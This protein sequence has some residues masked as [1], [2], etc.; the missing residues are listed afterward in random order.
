MLNRNN[1]KN[2]YDLTPMQEGILL[3]FIKNP[4]SV[5]YNEQFDFTLK[6]EISSDAIE[7]SFAALVN[8]YDVLR[9]LFSYKKTDRPKQIVLKSWQPQLRVQ[10]LSS[11]E[12]DRKLQEWLQIKEKDHQQRFNLSSDNLIRLSLIKFSD[13]HCQL[14][15]TFHH[16]ILDGWCFSG[17]LADFFRYYDIFNQ[18]PDSII[19]E[20]EAVT[21]AQ[22]IDWIEKQNPQVA[23]DYW[24]NYLADYHNEVG[25]PYFD[26]AYQGDISHAEYQFNLG[27]TLTAKMIELSKQ[28]NVTVNGLFQTAWGVLLQKIN[29]T[30]DV[31]FG[32]VV[33]GRS[34]QMANIESVMGL[35]MNTQA[36]RVNCKGE[37]I[38]S[39]QVK[40]VHFDSVNA[41]SFEYYPLTEIQA[42]TPLKNRLINHALT[43]ENLP[44]N[45]QVKQMT[46]ASDTLKV[47]EVGIFQGAKFD[48]HVIVFPGDQMKVS[49]VYNANRYTEQTM[50][51][52]SRS[53]LKLFDGIIQNPHSQIEDLSICSESDRELIVETYNKTAT[54]YPRNASVAE[55]FIQQVAQTP[56]AI[57]LRYVDQTYSYLELHQQALVA[58]TRLQQLNVKTKDRIALLVSRSPEMVIGM[59]AT[60]YCGATYVPLETS[61]SADRIGLMLEDASVSVVVTNDTYKAHLSETVMPESIQFLSLNARE[62]TEL[63][64]LIDPQ[65]VQATDEAYIMYTSGSTGKPKGCAIN[66]RSI[67]RLVKNTNYINLQPGD[68]F[69]Q[70]GAPAFDASTLEIWGSLLNGAT[71]CLVDENVIIDHQKL[72]KALLDFS[73]T[74]MW[75]TSALFNQLCEANS[76]MFASL[77]HL[78]VGG[79]VLSVKYINAVRSANP[80]LKVINGYG[81][82]ENTTFS[83]TCL[84]EQD[85]PGKIPVGKP[86]ANSTAYILDKKGKLLPPGAIGEL[87]VGGDGVAL[88][89]INRPELTA[90]KFITVPFTDSRLYRTGD[91]SRWLDDG[92][93]ELLGR[94]DFQVKIRGFRVELGE[95]EK[96]FALLSGIKQVVVIAA[97]KEQPDTAIESREG[98]RL[99]AFYTGDQHYEIAELRRLLRNYLPQYMLPDFYLQM[100][101]F[102]LTTSGK[103]DRRQLPKDECIK[104]AFIKTNERPRSALEQ[105]VADICQN[106]LDIEQIGI[107]DNFFD[108]GANSLNLVA[109][110]NRLNSEFNK[111]TDKE[112][113]VTI[114]FEYTTVAA[115]SDY[116][117]DDGNAEKEKLEIENQQLDKAKSALSKTKKLSR[118]K[119]RL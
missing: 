81:P 63:T 115:L 100:Q 92:K 64:T 97:E 88:E 110:N 40:Q 12:G 13:E 11:F 25:V 41:K 19:D 7:K 82:T 77:S 33:S 94:N 53:F 16:I 15:L 78:L 30:D 87:C 111:D 39:E 6:G 62:K 26:H 36:T 20:Q 117:S 45:E 66:H 95:I 43:F 84:I 106:V 1:V 69:L 50:Q 116:L 4:N 5:A 104:Y 49:F 59:L 22:Y 109:I 9:S 112:I 90:E 107:N 54:D 56:D 28:L 60:L 73:A 29:N 31:V 76:E 68:A 98:K 72:A 57:A 80:N 55:L 52:L 102:P 83:A 14:L 3:D 48:F 42:Q 37:T 93:I 99:Y 24:K 18:S 44:I 114:M 89:Y 2:I 118:M 65:L 70:T 74:H 101:E 79:D 23:K 38:F 108:V 47:A 21:F 86:I 8:K 85:Y 67:V 32:H 96:T 103:V 10:D 35:F 91:L 113:P 46:A 119:V 75:L 71:L 58:A 17:L 27:E 51:S 105:K 61:A 34:S